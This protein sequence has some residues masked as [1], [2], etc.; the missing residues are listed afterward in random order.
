MAGNDVLTVELGWRGGIFRRGSIGNCVRG[1][2][3]GLDGSRGV[4]VIRLM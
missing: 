4:W 2:P 3:L 1:L